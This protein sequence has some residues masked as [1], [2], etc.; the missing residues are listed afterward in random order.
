MFRILLGIAA[1]VVVAFPGAAHHSFATYYFEDQSVT[2]EG[3]VVEFDYR[4]P[5]A[6][7]HVTAPDAQGQMRRF[8]AEWANPRRLM[9]DGVTRD[10]LKPGDRVVITGSPG[11]T[12]AEYKIHLKRIQRRA[13]G[14]A[15]DMRRRGRQR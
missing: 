8:S 6:W 2:I 5:H 11:R 9:G 1:A 10:T 12:P 4:A 7:L 15:W 13:D 3:D 14:W